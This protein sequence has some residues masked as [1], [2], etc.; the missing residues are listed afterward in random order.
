M[1]T[2]NRLQ[3]VAVLPYISLKSDCEA[4]TEQLTE[5]SQNM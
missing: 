2:P 3:P 5:G 4:Q 1:M